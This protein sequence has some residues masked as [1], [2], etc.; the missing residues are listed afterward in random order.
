MKHPKEF[1]KDKEGVSPVI[2]VIL[3]VAITVIMAA[4]V[5]G[6]VFGVISTPQATPTASI[7]IDNL[8]TD[9]NNVTLLLQSGDTIQKNELRIVVENTTDGDSVVN[10]TF[11]DAEWKAGMTWN[12]GTLNPTNGWSG[13]EDPLSIDSGTTYEVRIIHKPSGNTITTATETA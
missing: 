11:A 8:D 5:A 7:T 4:I 10:N 13:D 2:G 3:M 9:T 12:L 1:L 6:F